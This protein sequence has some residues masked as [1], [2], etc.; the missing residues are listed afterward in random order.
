VDFVVE[1]LTIDL[2]DPEENVLAGT[3][4]PGE[5]VLIGFGPDPACS[6]HVLADE[7]GAW[8]FD[9]DDLGCDLTA[10]HGAYAQ[11]FDP[12]S[13]TTEVFWMTGDNSGPF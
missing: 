7:N 12:E 4:A 2:L 11:V 3:A 10:D 5:Q 6:L 9:F 13:D 8:S 1:P